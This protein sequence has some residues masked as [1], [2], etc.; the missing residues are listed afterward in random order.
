MGYEKSIN[1]SNRISRLLS[2]KQ[3]DGQTNP[4]A[5]SQ[6]QEK[7]ECHQ[8]VLPSRDS[9]SPLPIGRKCA[10]DLLSDTGPWSAASM[11]NPGVAAIRR[12]E[13]Y[14]NQ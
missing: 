13:T 11:A 3:A 8:E 6:E 1:C 12:C 9:L 4:Q 5:H 2:A 10:M 14:F 7:S